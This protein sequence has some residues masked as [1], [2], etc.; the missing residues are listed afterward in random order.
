MEATRTDFKINIENKLLRYFNVQ[1]CE[2]TEDQF[3]K[4]TALVIK[5]KLTAQR[6]EYQKAVKNCSAKKVYYLCME[7]LVGRQLKNNLMNLG[8]YDDFLQA[9][10]D[11]GFE[12]QKVFDC[13]RDP[14]L[15]NGGLGR[16]AAC[17]MDALASQNYPATA[18]SICYEYGLFR[19][20]IV[21]GEQIELPD[22]WLPGGEVWL[23]PRSDRAYTVKFGGKIRENWSKDGK[24][25]I[26]H[27]NYEE[28]QAMPYDLLIS[29]AQ[30]NTVNNL[31]LWKA[32]NTSKFNMHLFSQG[33]Y[34]KA[35]EE[36]TNAEIISKVLYPSDN[37]SEGKLL[38][39]TQQYFL[40]SASLQSIITDHL[41]KY[42]TLTGFE[43]KN[44]IHINDTH[45]AL[46][47]PELMRI[48]IDTY[49]YGWDDAWNIVKRTVSYTNHT[50]LPEALECWDEAL[51]KL[52][53]PRIHMIVQELN[54]RFCE[55]L[56]KSYPGDWD[57][58][59]NMSVLA[60]D[61][62]RM[63]N[64]SVVGSYCVNGVSKLHSDILKKSIFH[65]FYK[66]T[67]QKFTNITN[68]ISHRRW[69][70][71]NNEEL[72]K[73]LDCCIGDGYR[74]S[75]HLLYEFGNYANDK[76]ILS[77]LHEIK[78]NNKIK[79]SNMIYE[80][81]G[82]KINPHSF[83]DV[84]IKR[85]HEYKRQL[86]N[87]LKI[88]YLYNELIKNPD[89]ALPPQTYIFGAKAANNYYMAKRIIKLI[90]LI[91]RHIEKDKRINEK[92]KVVFVEDYNVSIAEVLIP[93]AELSEQISLAG[94]E[95]SGTSNMK[96]MINGAVTIGTLDG[97]NVEICEKAG[98]EN[99]YIFGLNAA[100]AD[101]LWRKG[102]A[103][104]EY[105]K[106][107]TALKEIMELLHEGL[108]GVCC[109]EFVNYFLYSGDVPDPYM[110][111]ADFE[112][113]INCYK[114]ALY[115]YGCTQEWCKKSLY[116]IASAGYFSA[117]RSINEY[118]DKI[119]KVKPV[120]I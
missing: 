79:F 22:I 14:G 20:K 83:F 38:R 93:A 46:V 23:V 64:L 26:I 28:I 97:A 71:Y 52:K 92:L 116:N 57:R 120:I 15:G 73:L 117:E 30:T 11:Y 54:K 50:V 29:G 5:E 37:H 110:C 41:R 4:A 78:L 10:T 98:K 33:E 88:M 112:S 81:T 85:M 61:K 82:V 103:S 56:W 21:D 107:S 36:S 44:A 9:A 69:L 113:Y 48:F 34:V 40:V 60:C 115:D 68:G 86:L 67:P 25:E 12:I 94:K 76:N 31:R 106:R 90:H 1:P 18:F 47:I 59:S 100:E 43:E 70:C 66:H 27:E 49:S 104:S 32:Q 87:A 58:I 105:Y 109:D 72:C 53:L 16:L 55:E 75:P 39:L 111:F 19:Q 3:Y 119:W 62:V 96:L 35:M 114:K 63:A 8:L 2:A 95:A 51:F 77:K 91:A 65:D 13:E 45:P 84:Q 74:N 6:A 101:E 17:Y 7:F 102:Y 89:L 99:C 24:C 80:K 42:G 108:D 118:A